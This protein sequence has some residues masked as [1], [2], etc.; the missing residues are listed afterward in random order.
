M[1]K[2][3]EYILSKNDTIASKYKVSFPVKKGYYAESYRV[4]DPSGEILFLK[5]IDPSKLHSTQLTRDGQL[6]EIQFVK[7][8]DNPYVVNYK[9]HGEVISG[10]RKYIYLLM[11]FIS[12]ETVAE[13]IQI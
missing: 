3:T 11:I 10:N 5:L 9:D 7:Q 4:I 1:N 13:K 12:G 2:G 6:T 8:L